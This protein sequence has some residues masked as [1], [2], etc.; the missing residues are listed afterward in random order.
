MLGFN[1]ISF[2]NKSSLV[3]LSTHSVLL[4]CFCLQSSRFKTANNNWNYLNI[5][6]NS[7]YFQQRFPFFFELNRLTYSFENQLKILKLDDKEISLMLSLL[8]ISIGLY[9]YLHNSFSHFFLF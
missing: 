4:M 8:I 6:S 9:N 7:L 3:H 1:S 5:S 2:D